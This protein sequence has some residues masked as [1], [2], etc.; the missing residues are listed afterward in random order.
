MSDLQ[1]A[2]IIAIR[3]AVLGQAAKK[4]NSLI[5]LG[6]LFLLLG[7]IGISGQVMY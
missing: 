6:I 5:W 3:S 2:Q 4:P 7:V 1:A